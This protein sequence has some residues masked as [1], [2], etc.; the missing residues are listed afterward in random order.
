[1]EG[2]D[3]MIE[4][5]GMQQTWATHPWVAESAAEVRFGIANGPRG[6]WS[7]LSEF[8]AT[9]EELEI[10]A[11]WSSDHPVLSPG[12]WTTLAALAAT[13]RRIRLG[14]LVACT[15]YLN[16]VVLARTALDIDQ[17]SNGRLIVGLGIGDIEQEFIQ[18]GVP[19]R[20]T[21]ERQKRLGEVIALLRHL[22]GEGDGTAP[23]N[24]FG[25]DAPPLRPGPVQRPRIPTL[26]AGG[27][28]RVTLRQVARCADA[29]NFGEHHYAGGV[30]GAESIMRRMNALDG[31]CAAFNRPPSSVLRTHTTYPLVIAESKAGAIEKAEHHIPAWVRELASTSIVAGTPDDAIAHFA[32]L[33]DAGLQHFIAFVYGH[34]LETVRLL[35]ERV[36]PHVRQRQVA[37]TTRA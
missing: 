29:S 15:E 1:M 17:T 31:H 20:T 7:A 28:E 10:D 2:V 16:P 26:I 5:A 13:T 36:I 24:A 32:R 6:D 27:G 3:M 33:R 35:A 8:V 19:W 9:L 23:V 12:C 11:Y 25:I 18:M 30:Q 14:S 34:D 4:T 37:A 21:Q 22:W